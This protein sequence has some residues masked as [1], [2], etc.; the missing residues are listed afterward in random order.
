VSKPYSDNYC[1][2]CGHSPKSHV[3]RLGACR[4]CHDR[5]W[6]A[7]PGTTG[8]CHGFVDPHTTFT[9]VADKLR[10]PQQPQRRDPLPRQLRDLHIVAARLGCYEAANWI[11]K[12]GIRASP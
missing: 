2:K 3:D 8:R 4:V 12:V 7:T 1:A 5:D 10:I 9:P 6:G 11:W